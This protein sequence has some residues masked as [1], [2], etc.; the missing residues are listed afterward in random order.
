M[1]L[2]G[3][4]YPVISG[5][6]GNVSLEHCT[7]IPNFFVADVIEQTSVLTGH[8][9]YPYSRNRSEFE[10]NVLLCNYSGSSESSSLAKYND[11][12]QYKDKY[13]Y[14]LPHSDFTA[15]IDG[16]GGGVEYFMTEFIPYYLNNDVRYDAI[17]ITLSPRKNSILFVRT[18]DGYGTSFGLYYGS[19]G[20]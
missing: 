4:S 17:S 3:T 18:D 7:L 9:M 8:K 13:F 19:T 11:I 6:L 1:S 20:W 10:L 2:Y 15:S 16:V 5:S 12:Y 14:F